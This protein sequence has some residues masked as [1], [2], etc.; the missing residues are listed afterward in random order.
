[1]GVV[2]AHTWK[3]LVEQ[4]ELA[5]K[6]PTKFEPSVPRIDGE[7]TTRDVMQPSLPKKNEKK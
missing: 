6:S 3:D 7:S 2:K 1:M 5:E 4:A